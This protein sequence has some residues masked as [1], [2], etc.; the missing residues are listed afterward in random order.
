MYRDLM[1]CSYQF[2]LGKDGAARKA[3][4]VVLDVWNQITV[5]NGAGI[6]GS[7][8][9]TRPLAAVLLGYEMESG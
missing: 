1:I 9:S 5:R 8:V 6:Q 2:N 3:V 4:S 7:V